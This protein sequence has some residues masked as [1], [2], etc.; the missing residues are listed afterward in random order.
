MDNG[1]SFRC[2]ADTHNSNDDVDDNNHKDNT[3][4]TH[5]TPFM[6]NNQHHFHQTHSKK[7]ETPH[8]PEIKNE[9]DLSNF[10]AYPDEE[11]DP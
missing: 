5:K 2:Y 4:C 6:S 7:M 9:T 11:D 8:K 10:D 1:E 3:M